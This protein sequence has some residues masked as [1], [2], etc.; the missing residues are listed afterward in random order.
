MKNT[1]HWAFAA[2][3]AIVLSA[4]GGG[5]SGDP[6]AALPKSP[7]RG[8]LMESTPTR[9]QSVSATDFKASLSADVI[10]AT[11]T[12]V[13]GVDVNYLKYA[14]VGAM[15]EA[16]D[17]TAALMVPTGSDPR[18]TGPRPIVLYAHGTV[19]H[20]KYNLANNWTER[21]NPAFDES[22]FIAASFAA[23][24]YILVAPN[25]AGYDSSSLSYHPYM[26]ADQ[27][28][29][30]MMDALAAAKT[31]LPKL[32]SPTTASSKLFITG[33]S[34]GG[35]VTMA[36]HRALEAANIPVTASAP[37]S[38]VFL[39]LAQLDA[40]FLG[41]VSDAAPL[42][43]TMLAISAQKSFGNLYKQPSDIF[44]DAYATGIESLVPGN[45][46]YG[47]LIN[48]GKLPRALFSSTPPAGLADITPAKGDGDFD[49][50]YAAGFGSPN[51]LKNSVRASYVEDAR[52]RPD[53]ALAST[54]NYQLPA[55]PTHPFRMTGKAFDLR[56]W[57]PKAPM[58][59]CGGHGDAM[60]IYALNTAAM[61]TI[62]KDL[63]P[64]ITELDI[65]SD[66][67]GTND[68]FGPIKQNFAK[69]K[70]A[71]YQEYFQYLKTL[72]RTDSNAASNAAAYV[73][74]IYHPLLVPGFCGAAV[75][76]YFGRF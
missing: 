63:G 29:K 73:R 37:Q 59:L 3:S 65:D 74:S 42:F 13:C 14:T 38:G 22:V 57:T 1:P 66:P 40:V 6:L 31:A 28:S 64:Q 17:A 76:A 11:G 62:W 48:N 5:N 75:N 53:G 61:K 67:S 10:M 16:T 24:G 44:E 52:A 45:F 34:Q 19:P 70:I 39:L 27:Q 47:D 36:T 51:L 30:D 4:C 33:Y 2:I 18:C 54:P 50:L 49:T 60:A 26:N 69:R 12:P 21:T 35:S 8:V 15:G 20:K 23:Q 9:I 46:S 58:L 7:A 68:P 56:G 72:G 71:V 25:Y 32:S 41:K 55:A 43:G